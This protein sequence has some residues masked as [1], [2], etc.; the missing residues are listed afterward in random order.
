VRKLSVRANFFIGSIRLRHDLVA[1]EVEE[2]S[3]EVSV[4]NCWKSS[5]NR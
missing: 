3:G 1:P 2:L 5:F 4:Q